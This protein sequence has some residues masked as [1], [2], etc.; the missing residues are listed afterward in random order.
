[1]RAVYTTPAPL[2]NEGTGSPSSRQIIFTTSLVPSLSRVKL[3]VVM[4]REVCTNGKS[5]QA[6]PPKA[7]WPRT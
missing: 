3:L 2:M 5:R 6:L 7:S 4:A 1:V